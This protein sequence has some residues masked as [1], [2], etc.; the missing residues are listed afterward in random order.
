MEV[1]KKPNFTN[2]QI[3]QYYRTSN[4]ILTFADSTSE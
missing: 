4:N 1:P 2:K 3:E